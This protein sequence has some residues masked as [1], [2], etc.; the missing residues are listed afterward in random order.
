[1]LHVLAT[2]SLHSVHFQFSVLHPVEVQEI[3]TGHLI[4]IQSFKM[5]VYQKYFK[6]DLSKKS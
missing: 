2:T 1:M 6:C 4:V 5:A 3:L